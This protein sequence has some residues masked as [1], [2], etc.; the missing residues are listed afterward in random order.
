MTCT[1]DMRRNI[2]SR[3]IFSTP[4]TSEKFEDEYLDKNRAKRANEQNR[5]KRFLRETRGYRDRP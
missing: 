1:A 2:I 5:A 3:P 4:S